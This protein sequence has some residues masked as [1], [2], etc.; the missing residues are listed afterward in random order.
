MMAWSET[1]GDAGGC[2]TKSWRSKFAPWM[3]IAGILTCFGYY[4][5]ARLGFALTFQPH[6]VSV[7]WPPNSILL[8]A[9]LLTPTRSWW[10]LLL[11]ALPAHLASQMQSG[12]PPT[13]MLCWFVSNSC[14]ALIGASLTRAMVAA[15]F[16]L[17]SLR[18][19]S[20]FL[21]CGVFLG[22]F[23][24]SFLDAGFVRWNHWGQGSYGE[25]WRIR[26][27]SNVLTAVALVPALVTCFTSDYKSIRQAEVVRWLEA[28]VVA[29]GV[30]VVGFEVFVKFGTGHESAPGL[31]YAPLPFLLWA[32]VRF[33]PGGA[34]MVMLAISLIAIWGAAHGQGPFSARTAEANAL[35][36]QF[37]LIVSAIL[38]LLLATVIKDRERAEAA[39]RD[40]EGR[41]R[42]VV[43]SQTNL[44]CRHLADSTLT[45]VND[46]Y[47]RFLVG[48]YSAARSR[49][50][51]PAHR[52]PE[53][54]AWRRDAGNRSV[55]A[56]RE[57][58]LVPM[59]GLSGQGNRRKDGGV[60]SRRP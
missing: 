34:S 8:A 21:F 14:E 28:A 37:F 30:L 24:S 1:L 46:A 5:G 51:V 6:P 33:G 32:A 23:L 35:S 42:E 52:R 22:P 15:P 11:C 49:G 53:P 38:L 45:F 55:F 3:I 60:S 29:L 57:H 56:G 4:L 41:Y 54:G 20:V 7:M 2:A 59:D 9:L 43:E 27:F 10:F 58:C 44:V 36:L 31:L 13:M 17:A 50:G 12:V 18:N 48:L 25:I 26:F 19:V 47:C 16:R 39:L 40:S